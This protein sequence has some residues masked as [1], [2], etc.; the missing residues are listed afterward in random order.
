MLYH[1][2][3]MLMRLAYRQKKG[4]CEELNSGIIVVVAA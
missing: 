2:T 4:G 3:Y 1:I